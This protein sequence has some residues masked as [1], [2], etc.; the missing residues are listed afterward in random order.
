MFIKNSD[1]FLVV[2]EYIHRK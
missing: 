1:Q 2:V